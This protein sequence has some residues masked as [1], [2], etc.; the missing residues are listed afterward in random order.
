MKGF[1]RYAFI[2]GCVLFVILLFTGVVS[3]FISEEGFMFGTIIILI[4]ICIMSLFLTG[5]ASLG[6]MIVGKT[7]KV[8]VNSY[9]F[10]FSP[11]DKEQVESD[12]AKLSKIDLSMKTSF[13][14]YIIVCLLLTVGFL[15]LG[16]SAGPGKLQELTI[17]EIKGVAMVIGIAGFVIILVLDLLVIITRWLLKLKIKRTKVKES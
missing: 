17:N 10:L 8:L 1:D 12:V 16:A 6:I 5:V 11:R 15:V 4:G 3:K 13:F 9:K 7:I 2:V 14:L